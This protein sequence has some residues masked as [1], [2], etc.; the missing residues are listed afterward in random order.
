MAEDNEILRYAQEL[1]RLIRPGR[2]EPD[3]VTWSGSLPLDRVIVR[4]GE[5]TLPSGMKGRLRPEDWRPLIASSII[6]RQYQYVGQRTGSRVRLFL[7][8]TV[9]VI[10]LIYALLQAGQ[11]KTDQARIELILVAT[12]W[13]LFVSSLMALY[14]HWLRRSL[15]YAADKRAA[16]IVGTMTILESLRKSL[17]AT[18]GLIVTGKR[19][20]LLPSLN[21]RIQKL[22]RNPQ[23]IV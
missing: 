2:S 10:P 8:T 22:E 11:M 15:F 7:P 5:V 3:E 14:I 20:S 23:T 16:E 21:Q 13:T 17:D 18:S 1:S 6:Y 12:V 19:F 4:Y 9:G